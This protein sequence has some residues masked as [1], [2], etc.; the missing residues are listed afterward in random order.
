MHLNH[1]ICGDICGMSADKMYV[2]QA[3][4]EVYS[5]AHLLPHL[6]L[7]VLVEVQVLSPVRGR[8]AILH[9][10]FRAFF[11]LNNLNFYS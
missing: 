4:I 3:H 6:S 1:W 10:Q 2:G 11:F 9:T 7:S 8:A 5:S